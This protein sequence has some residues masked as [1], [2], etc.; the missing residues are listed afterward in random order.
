MYMPHALARKYLRAGFELGWQ[1]LFPASQRS[2]DARSGKI[3]R[4]HK[5]EMALQRAVTTAVGL[6]RRLEGNGLELHL[7]KARVGDWRQPEQGFEFLR[8]ALRPAAQGGARA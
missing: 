2:R 6:A 7:V 3:M 1:Y 4:H 8:Y 5:N